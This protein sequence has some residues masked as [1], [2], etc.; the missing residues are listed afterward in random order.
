[1]ANTYAT[2][3]RNISEKKQLTVASFGGVDYSSKKFEVENYHA[4]YA[5]NYYKKDGCLQKRYGIKNLYNS[6]FTNKVFNNLWSFVGEDN[7]E[8]YIANISTNLYELTFDGENPI[9]TLIAEAVVLDRKVFAIPSNNR[10]YILGG[11]HYLMLKVDAKTH[12]ISL[13]QLND[14]EFAYVPRTTIGITP[15]GSAISERTSLDAMNMLTYWKINKL[16]SGTNYTSD[17][18]HTVVVNSLQSFQLDSTI[19]WREGFET[20]DMGKFY[21]KIE[22]YDNNTEDFKINEMN[23]LKTAKFIAVKIAGINISDLDSTKTNTIV[24]SDLNSQGIY[25]LLDSTKYDRANDASFATQ[26]L[27]AVNTKDTDETLATGYKVYGYILL[28]GTIT[29]FNDYPNSITNSNI[30][31]YYPHWDSSRNENSIDKCFIGKVF[32]SN[33]LGS[34]FCCGDPLNPA[35]DWHTEEINSSQLNDEELEL[36]GTNDLVYFPDTSYCKYGKD[37]MNPIIGY[38][39]LGTGTLMVLKKF[40]KYEATIYFRNGKMLTVTDSSG[41]TATDISGNTLYKQEYSLIEG[42][43]GKSAISPE[44]IINF[45]GDTLFIAN[46]N[47][48]EGLDKEE[49][50]YDNQRYANSRSFYIDEYLKTKDMSKAFFY[51]DNDYLMLIIG[52]EVFVYKYGEINNKNYEW[53]HLEFPI[54]ICSIIRIGKHLYFGNNKGSLFLYDN[55]DVFQDRIRFEIASGEVLSTA[56]SDIINVNANLLTKLRVG[57]VLYSTTDL[58]EKLGASGTDF[59]ITD[60]V[61]TLI[62]T[63]L[64]DTLGKENFIVYNKQKF[65]I[66]FDNTQAIGVYK[67]NMTLVGDSNVADTLGDGFL[68]LAFNEISVKSMDLVASTFKCNEITKFAF[69]QTIVGYFS[70]RMNV[71]AQYLTAPYIFGSMNYLKNLWKV[72]LTNDKGIKGSLS[73]KIIDNDISIEQTSFNPKASFGLTLE[74]IDFGTFGTEKNVLGARWYTYRLDELRKNFVSFDFYN[75]DDTNSVLSAMQIIYSYGPQT[76]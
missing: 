53:Y 30:T 49:K 43:I 26:I 46:D 19:T 52:K 54:E 32:T 66:K 72:T 31:V 4:I 39:V 50:A 45:N 74:D 3:A 7:I 28:D 20:T 67:Y 17:T 1:M 27:R 48:I 47:T 51:D 55:T 21:L 64:C 5:R 14:S 44:G 42:N 10:L 13:I 12:A 58:L 57:D 35:T 37:N 36:I 24:D 73:L 75:E 8:H 6:L 70:H 23:T 33:N 25:V 59:T 11:I 76:Y 34:L 68:Y 38:D 65:T 2:T 56:N 71:V 9:F 60:N 63:S 61:L 18:G 22:F 40:Q 16:V 62:T 69:A 15:I 29:L 41:A